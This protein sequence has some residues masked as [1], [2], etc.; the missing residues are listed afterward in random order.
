M[1]LSSSGKQSAYEIVDDGLKS[2]LNV[3]LEKGNKK[4][5]YDLVIRFTTDVEKVIGQI[6]E[7]D[8][9]RMFRSYVSERIPM[10]K[11]WQ[12]A[13]PSNWIGF[14]RN[15]NTILTFVSKY[16]PEA[17]QVAGKQQEDQWDL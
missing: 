10:F 15:Q 5:C 12:P 6:G 11:K 9:L 8:L 16:T 2:A 4:N 17:K 13:S 1:K 7:D 3:R 14:L